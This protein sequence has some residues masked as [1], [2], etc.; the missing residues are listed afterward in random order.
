MYPANAYVI[1]QAG[2]DDA[3][4]LQ[5]LLALNGGRPL[6]G[7][8]VG[9]VSG[10]VV[11][12]VSLEDGHVLADEAEAPPA[13]R[14]TLRMRFYAL[15]SYAETPSLPARLRASFAAFRAAHAQKN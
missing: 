9:E 11:A 1:R 7:S 10:V 15:R 14:Q 12:A 5:R 2:P 4:A 6:S 13:L 8:L 3:R